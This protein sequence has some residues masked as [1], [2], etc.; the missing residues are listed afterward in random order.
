MVGVMLID[1]AV[2]RR[3]KTVI[4]VGTLGVMMLVLVAGAATRGSRRWIDIGFFPFQPSEFGK[5][6]FTLFLAGFLADR[7]KR[8]GDVR[9]PLGAVALAAVPIALVFVQPDIGTAL[10]YTAVLAARAVR[11][12]A[13]AGPTSPRSGRSR[14]SAC[15]RSSGGCPPRA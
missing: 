2:Y 13:C 11:R 10:V 8:M 1:P 5:V 7:A 15:S 14:S 6:L 3:F 9:V 12:P 4:Y